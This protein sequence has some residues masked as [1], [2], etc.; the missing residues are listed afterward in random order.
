MLRLTAMGLGVGC[1]ADRG[2]I[3]VRRN[4][5]FYFDSPAPTIINDK[6]FPYPIIFVYLYPNNIA[7]KNI[8]IL[9]KRIL[10]NSEQ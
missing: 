7:T 2:L 9:W 1:G 6:L 4:K 10:L 5:I 3:G 8:G